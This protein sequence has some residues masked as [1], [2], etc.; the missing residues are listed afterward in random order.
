MRTWLL[1]LLALLAPTVA[2]GSSERG[3]GSPGPDATTLMDEPSTT[4]SVPAVT[5]PATDSQQTF[6]TV[7]TT[8]TTTT[9]VPSVVPS[10]DLSVFTGLGAGPSLEIV[11]PQVSTAPG[12]LPTAWTRV[13][14]GGVAV[15]VG[16][17]PYQ[18]GEVVVDLPFVVVV[19]DD[20]AIRWRRPASSITVAPIETQPTV[21][22][23]RDEAPDGTSQI[24]AVDIATGAVV[25]VDP[26]VGEL[27]SLASSDRAWLLGSTRDDDTIL[28]ESKLTVVDLVDGSKTAV[29]VPPELV[30]RTF[31]SVRFEVAA[32]GGDGGGIAV[33]ARPL[34]E[35]V[36]PMVFVDDQWWTTPPVGVAEDTL[37]VRIDRSS[38]SLTLVDWRGSVLWSLAGFP[39]APREGFQSVIGGKVLLAMRC[40]AVDEFG[41]AIDAAG[42]YLEELV[43]VDVRTGQVLWSLPGQRAVPIAGPT[44]AIMTV[45]AG[46][47]DATTNGYALIDVT[48]G[49][50][51][52]PPGPVWPDGSFTQECC[53]GGDFVHVRRDGGVVIAT[54]GD[55][56]RI[57][58]P[59][60]LTR[61]LVTATL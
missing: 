8:T 19:D 21:L 12:D 37:P 58:Y 14:P 30:G 39:M 46:E 56:V 4:E 53:G 31:G 32:G 20:G 51:V 49:E 6:N 7:A 2:C 57:W 28:A 35:T 16:E 34:D 59:P 27:A 15:L 17:P 3:S 44:T 47:F 55:R 42:G 13:V 33:I 61:P 38:D 24:T 11:L 22:W 43:A 10:V 1:A 9:V 29:G 48:T 36:P 60:E 52:G 5:T 50:R 54:D 40:V 41:C 18:S 45:S 25:S 23:I 26:I